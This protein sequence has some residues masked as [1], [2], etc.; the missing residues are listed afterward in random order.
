M[1]NPARRARQLQELE[2][3]LLLAQVQADELEEFRLAAL[4]S[5]ALDAVRQ[6]VCKNANKGRLEA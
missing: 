3:T 2:S 5:T 6:S 4:I 1:H